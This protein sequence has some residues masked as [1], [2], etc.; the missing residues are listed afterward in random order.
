MSESVE[1]KSLDLDIE[2][3]PQYSSIACGLIR[4]SRQNEHHIHVLST[5]RS[6]VRKVYNTENRDFEVEIRETSND[7][8]LAVSNQIRCV[9]RSIASRDESRVSVIIYVAVA[10]MFHARRQDLPFR[11]KQRCTDFD[12]AF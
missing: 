11:R 2:E 5:T 4:F 1:M 8:L 12:L 7:Q 9:S 6:P 3:K 10:R